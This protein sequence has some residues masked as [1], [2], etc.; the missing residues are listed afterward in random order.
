MKGSKMKYTD[1]G[2]LKRFVVFEFEDYYPSGGLGDNT[3]MFDTEDELDSYL[4]SIV[5]KRS[6]RDNVEVFDIDCRR[7]VLL[8][9][10]FQLV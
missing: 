3:A 1:V 2:V 4:K 7:E 9:E 10:N 8:D 6:H 5:N